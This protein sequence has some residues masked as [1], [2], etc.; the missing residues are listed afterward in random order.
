MVSPRTAG[1]HVA[2]LI[3]HVE[4]DSYLLNFMSFVNFSPAQ[5]TSTVQNRNLITSITRSLTVLSTDPHT[6]S[7]HH[8]EI[9]PIFNANACLV[10]T[11]KDT[12]SLTN[13]TNAC[14]FIYMA[15]TWFEIN[16]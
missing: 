10:M 9:M 2:K 7:L 15:A 3:L 4:H 13:L 5:N 12:A 6:T 16:E 1:L 11:L 14:V 8:Y